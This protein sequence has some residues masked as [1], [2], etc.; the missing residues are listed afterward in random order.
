MDE[1]MDEVDLIIEADQAEEVGGT[2]TAASIRFWILFARETGRPEDR[3]GAEE[4]LTQWRLDPEATENNAQQSR[5]AMQVG[6]TGDLAK[7][8]I[9]C[10]RPITS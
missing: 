1:V 4:W 2:H 10:Y 6:A 7:I 5:R 8:S 9:D 3:R